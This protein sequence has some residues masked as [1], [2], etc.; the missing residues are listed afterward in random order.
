MA[1]LRPHFIEID[2]GIEKI[3]GVEASR[4][5]WIDVVEID[6]GRFGVWLGHDYS[7]ALDVAEKVRI[8]FE[9]NEPVRDR[10]GG[11]E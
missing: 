2:T 7:N 4:V 8:D 1:D 11:D 3:A 9:V 6:G 5:F 10:V